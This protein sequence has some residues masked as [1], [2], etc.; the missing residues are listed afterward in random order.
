VLRS[1]A[2]SAK[3]PLAIGHRGA[4]AHLP[5]NTMPS[6]A[7]ALDLGA[8]ALEFDVTL[9]RDGVPVVIHDDSVNR[10][11]DGHG[12]VGDLSFDEIR[13][14]DAGFGHATPEGTPRIAIPSL[15]EVLDAFAKRTL[16]NLEIKESVRRVELVDACVRLVVEHRATGAVLFSSFDHNALYLVRSLLPEA[17]IGVLC[18]PSNLVGA[19]RCAA[20]LAAETIHPPV[21]LVSA[22]FVKKAH[23]AGLQVWTW[24]ANSPA[25]IARMIDAGVDGIFSDWPERIVAAR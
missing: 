17:R 19:M 11:T 24:T 6:F 22:A 7:K 2:M 21:V 3:L 10:T 25:T 1:D 15:A 23:E 16:L 12:A 8:D 5:E 14:L 13:R 18:G 9:T 4:A 20:E